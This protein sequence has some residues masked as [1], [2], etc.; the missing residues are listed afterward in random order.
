MGGVTEKAHLQDLGPQGLK[1]DQDNRESPPKLP[2][3]KQTST[4]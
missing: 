4:M 1:L 3:P 2:L